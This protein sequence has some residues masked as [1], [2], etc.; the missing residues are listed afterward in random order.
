MDLSKFKKV[1]S[2]DLHTILR[3]KAGHEI[4]LNHKALDSKMVDALGKL[5]MAKGGQVKQSN[6]K[7]E[8]SKKLPHYADGGEAD[9]SLDY[10]PVSSQ[11]VD[12]E[13][14][15]TPPSSEEIAAMQK[16]PSPD[17]AA[18][19]AP[20]PSPDMT[21]PT[22]AAPQQPAAAT[23]TMPSAQTKKA[24]GEMEIPTPRGSLE[25]AI[26]AVKLQDKLNRIKEEEHQAQAAQ[27]QAS[28]KVHE[29]AD[30]KINAISEKQDK[31]MMMLIDEVKN[32]KIEPGRL[33][34]NMGVW[35]KTLA[36]LSL[37]LG[38]LA[39][40]AEGGPNVA[41]DFLN[42]QIDRDIEAQKADK[43]QRMSLYKIN[44]QLLG[45][46]RAAVMKTK[47]EKL[48][49]LALQTQQ[50]IVQSNDKETKL[51]GAQLR[52]QLLDNAGQIKQGLVFKEYLTSEA[53]GAKLL[54]MAP[55][56][57]LDQFISPANKSSREPALKEINKAEKLSHLSKQAMRAFDELQ[58]WYSG[59]RAIVAA[60]GEAA[61]KIPFTGGALGWEPPQRKILRDIIA[62]STK[63]LVGTV[64]ELPMEKAEEAYVPTLQDLATGQAAIK[65]RDFRDYMSSAMEDANFRSITG[66]PLSKFESTSTP[67]SAKEAGQPMGAQK[68]YEQIYKG[69]GKHRGKIGVFEQG[70]NKFLGWKQ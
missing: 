34:S 59:P 32:R 67:I 10:E 66:I 40:G 25:Q 60:A 54:P 27:L 41:L 12:Y 53:Q 36:G 15:Q 7:L 3:H 28:I 2:D 1:S 24:P 21:A 13:S 62:Q 35:E 42:K 8:E 48:N 18:T 45:D 70:T 23:Q 26:D 4:K 19:M 30:R 57:V 33:W 29:E 58:D 55:A 43:S 50:R 61:G 56:Q 68:T 52:Q 46:E 51:R 64:R 22:P 38:G 9:D 31:Q 16:S 37:F 5:K 6:P 39:S 47:M 49:L 65:L 17:M 63:E 14:A 20:T 11:G 69:E 44:L